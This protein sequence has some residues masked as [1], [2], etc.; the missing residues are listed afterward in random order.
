MSHEKAK[1]QEKVKKKATKTLK[2]K[3]V[4]KKAKKADKKKQNSVYINRLLQVLPAGPVSP[5]G[6]KKKRL[7]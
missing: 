6:Y 2:E 4:A 5:A 1:Q 3:R 7:S